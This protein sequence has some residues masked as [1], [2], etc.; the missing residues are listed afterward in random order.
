T[1]LGD[2]LPL[3]QTEFRSG[4]ESKKE[5]GELHAAD[6]ADPHNQ[7]A[8][9]V[10]FALSY[11]KG[12]NHTI[13]KPAEYGFWRDFTP[14][15]TP[16]WP[17]KLFS[18]TSAKPTTLEAVTSAFQPDGEDV[19]NKPN[20]WTYRRIINQQNF[21]PGTYPGDTSIVN[22]PQNDYLLGNPDQSEAENEKHL[23]R[24]KQLSLSLVY[25][26]QTEVPRADGGQGW[27][28]LRLRGD[29]TGTDDG[30]A[31]SP[32]I[33]ESR[34]IKALFTVLE[35]HVGKQQRAMMIGKPD[36][37][38]AEFHDSVGLGYYSIDLHPSTRGVNYID[39]PSL[40]YQIPLG[41][42]LPQ[43]VTNLLP[44]NKNIGTTH[45]TNGCYRL[46][47]TEWGIGEAVG[48]VIFYA[49][50]KKALPRAVREDKTMLADFQSFI[51]LQGVETEWKS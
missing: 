8:F 24:A 5:T 6:E 28:G 42:L 11:E 13:D 33:R 17:G 43:R 22:W 29:V 50:Q 18:L 15:L 3:T 39:V 25:W 45:I 27:P 46:H 26:L 4:A 41:A 44:A 19:G 37:K 34:R 16:P 36:N 20:L 14:Q 35:E 30:L 7:Q 10:C 48:M 51:R 12:A 49:L 40:P 21:K 9:T 23:V 1:E 2:L 38:A 47:P 31:K 32:Y